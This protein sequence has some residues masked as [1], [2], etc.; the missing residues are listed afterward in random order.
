VISWFLPLS[1]WLQGFF[2][3]LMADQLGWRAGAFS[4]C[5]DWQLLSTPKLSP[6]LMKSPKI[7]IIC[8]SGNVVAHDKVTIIGHLNK[9]KLLIWHLLF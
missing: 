4:G 8:G 1:L 2:H 7:D 5:A 9:L 6:E 3:E